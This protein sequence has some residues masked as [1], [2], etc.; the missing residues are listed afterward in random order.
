[1]R[2]RVTSPV[3]EAAPLDPEWLDLEQVAQVEVTS[4]DPAYPIEAALVPGVDSGWRAAQPGEQ[5]I[6]LVFDRPQR[7]SRMWLL[8]IEPD[9]LRTHEFVFRCQLTATVANR[10]GDGVQQLFRQQA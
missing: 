4:E 2:K 7:V 6:R 5:T 9:T 3:P 1:M 10:S 8:F